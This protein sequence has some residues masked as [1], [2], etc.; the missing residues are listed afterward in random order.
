[1]K[2]QPFIQNVTKKK[3]V[4][5]KKKNKNKEKQNKT[6]QNKTKNKKQ[7]TKNTKQKTKNKKQ[8]TKNKKKKQ[9][10]KKMETITHRHYSDD[11]Y[12]KYPE[13]VD[14]LIANASIQKQFHSN[15]IARNMFQVK[16]FPNNF[17]SLKDTYYSVQQLQA[18]MK[19]FKIVNCKGR[20]SEMV[21]N[22]YFYF[23]FSSK[24][25]HIQKRVRGMLL[26]KYLGLFGPAL[27]NPQLCINT[28]DFVSFN[29]LSTIP[30]PDFYSY[31]DE[32][33]FIYGFHRVHLNRLIIEENYYRNINQ[34]PINPYNRQPF[35]PIVRTQLLK[36]SKHSYFYRQKRQKE[37]I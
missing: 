14:R 18:I 11:L 24:I 31:Q 28:T 32:N 19:R 3:H 4:Q 25:I 13:L 26:R 20:K 36:I 9:K 29:E 8:N 21:V 12:K 5:E 10:T 2:K 1:M 34:P 15:R 22:I 37:T 27:K 6:K 17:E 30:F 33:N 7:K 16:T 23:Y 35:P